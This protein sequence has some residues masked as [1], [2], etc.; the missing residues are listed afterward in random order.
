METPKRERPEQDQGSRNCFP[1]VPATARFA[2]NIICHIKVN[3][4]EISL[5]FDYYAQRINL[6]IGMAL[7]SNDVVKMLITNRIKKTP[8][9]LRMMYNSAD[10]CGPMTF[11]TTEPSEFVKGIQGQEVKKIVADVLTT[12]GKDGDRLL[13]VATFP[14][15]VFLLRF[16]D[17]APANDIEMFHVMSEMQKS[18][19]TDAADVN[20]FQL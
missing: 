1:D 15:W 13:L 3:E 8:T 20:A 16:E 5:D 10:P 18:S 14:C 11:W 9:V 2:V 4:P 19:V 17:V 12:N 7:R 6:E